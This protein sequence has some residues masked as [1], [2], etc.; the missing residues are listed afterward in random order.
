MFYEGFEGY[1]FDE[2][3][4]AMMEYVRGMRIPPPA[5]PPGGPPPLQRQRVE[6]DSSSSEEE[7]EDE[8]DDEVPTGDVYF[9]LTGDEYDVP[10]VVPPDSYMGL[11][12]DQY[13]CQ[14]VRFLPSDENLN[15]GYRPKREVD[16]QILQMF[17]DLPQAFVD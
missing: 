1:G 8:E 12:D 17:F 9:T 15:D 10:F 11:V 5:L 14:L 3:L 4:A 16:K 7:E 6:S 13:L 2:D